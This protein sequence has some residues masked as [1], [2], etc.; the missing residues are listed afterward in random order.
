LYYVGN[1]VQILVFRPTVDPSVRRGL[2]GPRRVKKIQE[3]HKTSIY[4]P[5]E[6]IRQRDERSGGGSLS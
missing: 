6:L 5:M 4:C 2:D 1:F 3:V